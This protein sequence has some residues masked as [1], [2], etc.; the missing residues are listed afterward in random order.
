MTSTP[1]TLAKK[2]AMAAAALLVSGALG[3]PMAGQ[4]WAFPMKP[5]IKL[6]LQE[7]KQPRPKFVPARAGWNGPEEGSAPAAVNATYE[8]MLRQ[9]SA[10][11][12]RAQ[13]EA[14]ALPDWRVLAGIGL[15]IAMLRAAKGWAKSP[16]RRQATVFA[17]PRV[18]AAARPSAVLRPA[19]EGSEAA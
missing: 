14:A 3:G 19:I 11:Q 17:F 6:L 1:R 9:P 4:A 12:K 10:A 8:E 7:A 16:R 18:G 5:D 13:L 2:V 15:L